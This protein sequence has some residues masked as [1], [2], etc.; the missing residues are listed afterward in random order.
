MTDDIAY[1]LL[2][3]RTRDGEETTVYLVRLPLATTRVSLACFAEPTRL[4]HWSRAT[5][6]QEAIVAGFFVRDPYRPLGEVRLGGEV[7]AHEPIAAPWG[8]RRACIHIDGSL[9]LGPRSQFG[10]EPAGD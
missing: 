3:I 7:V 5:G 1:E 4:D 6:H 2:R 8:P 10:R 9:E